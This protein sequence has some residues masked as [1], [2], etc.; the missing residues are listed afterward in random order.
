MSEVG[1]AVQSE[2]L[3]TVRISPSLR[4][5]CACRCIFAGP[6]E[7][8]VVGPELLHYELG[9]VDCMAFKKRYVQMFVVT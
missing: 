5:N 2:C 3:V 1:F 4:L 6:T 7:K 8:V 9:A